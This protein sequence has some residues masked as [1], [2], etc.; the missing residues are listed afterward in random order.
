MVKIVKLIKYKKDNFKADK[1]AK[2]IKKIQNKKTKSQ[3]VGFK[4]YKKNLKLHESKDTKYAI[5]KSKSKSKTH[6]Y[7]SKSKT[8]NFKSHKFKSHISKSKITSSKSLPDLKHINLIKTSKIIQPDEL[9]ISDMTPYIKNS[10][11]DVYKLPVQTISSLDNEYIIAIPSYKRSDIIQTH[12]LAVLNIHK[13]NPECI[14][15]FVANKEEYIIYK[16]TLPSFLYNNIVIGSLGLKNQRNFIS[17]YY[18]DGANVVEMDDDIKSIMQL[19]VKRQL[20]KQSKKSK[21]SKSFKAS[22]SIKTVKPIE[23]L[24]AFI[25]RAFEMCIESNIFLWGIYPLVNPHFMTYKVTTDLRFIVGP[26]WGMINRHRPD[27]KLTV[28]EKE[29]S[30][31]TLQFWVADGAVLRFNNVGIETKYYKN[32]GGMQEEGKDRKEEALKSVYY[33][34]KMYPNL[35]KVSLTKK[36]GMPEIKMKRTTL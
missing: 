21:M 5:H 19:V 12:T 33:L 29:N 31:R 7:K 2:Q 20:S 26:M 16:Q 6:K 10:N 11:K 9:V 36:N 32:K 8:Y 13:I 35:T 14:T 30:E 27:L 17:E 1:L 22:T 18:P 28:D 24:D 4:T 25:K 34:N 15:I 3:Q 23:D